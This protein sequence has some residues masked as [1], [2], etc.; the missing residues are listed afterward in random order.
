M[1]YYRYSLLPK[2][3]LPEA[4]KESGGDPVFRF[5]YCIILTLVNFYILLNYTNYHPMDQSEIASAR[6][7][8]TAEIHILAPDQTKKESLLTALD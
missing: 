4:K 6:A 2:E 8:L 5:P 3:C 7:D 1:Q